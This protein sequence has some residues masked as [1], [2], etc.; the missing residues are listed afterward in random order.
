MAATLPLPF[1]TDAGEAL[2][3]GGAGLW[4]LTEHPDT[5]STL[6]RLD[7]ASGAVLDQIDLTFAP[8]DFAVGSKS[9]WLVDGDADAAIEL[10]AATGTV[11]STVRVGRVPVAIAVNDEAVWVA[12]ARDET[13]SRIEPETLNV[14]TIAVGGTPGDLAAVADG[15]WVTVTAG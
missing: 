11:R 15:A 6:S 4:V 3:I 8:T 2:A 1:E 7:P 14:T 5:P 13:V 10:D 12:N 9:V